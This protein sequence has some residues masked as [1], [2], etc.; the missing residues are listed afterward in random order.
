MRPPYFFQERVIGC[1]QSGFFDRFFGILDCNE[2]RFIQLSAKVFKEWK[3]LKKGNII[4]SNFLDPVIE[5]LTHNPASS[6]LYTI[7]NKTPIH[8]SP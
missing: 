6:I 3:P 4:V 5:E 2:I 1:N 7:I 8:L